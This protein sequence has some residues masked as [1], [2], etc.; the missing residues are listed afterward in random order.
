[1]VT[2]TLEFQ[3]GDVFLKAE[4]FDGLELDVSI[5]FPYPGLEHQNIRVGLEAGNFEKELAPARTFCFEKEVE[6]LRQQGLIKGGDLDCALVV[7]EK[8][9]LNLS[10]IK[11]WT[12]WVI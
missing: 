1:V 9:V 6:A 3:F 11:P 7:G 10:A 12:F 5:S 2:E 8:G 4:P